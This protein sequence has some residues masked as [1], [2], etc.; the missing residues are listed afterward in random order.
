VSHD[1]NADPEVWALT[2]GCGDRAL[3]VWLELLSISDRNDGY[4]PPMSPAL[5]KVLAGRCQV[6][7]KTVSAVWQVAND[8]AWIVLDPA[9]RVVKYRE[10]HR[11]REREKSQGG[12][13]DAPSEPSDLPEPSG[14]TLSGDKEVVPVPEWIPAQLWFDFK[15]MRQRIRKP[16]T[17]YAEHLAFKRLEKLRGEGE[18]PVAVLEQSILNSYPGLW[19]VSKG[20]SDARRTK[21]REILESGLT[22]DGKRS[23]QS[24]VRG[25]S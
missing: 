1:L 18:D 21:T 22:E 2:Q 25:S 5:A 23:I 8:Y 13:K 6:A 3:R 11:I 14:T 7:T 19:P 15:K 12:A 16:M 9:P 24:R 4:L 17:P 10:Y 20:K